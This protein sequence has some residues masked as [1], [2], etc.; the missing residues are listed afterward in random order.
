M[1][2]S[3]HLAMVDSQKCLM[4]DERNESKIQAVIDL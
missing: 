4:F 3:R 1:I 2:A